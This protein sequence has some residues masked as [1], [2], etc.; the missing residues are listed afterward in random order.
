MIRGGQ[1]SVTPSGP[2]TLK[3]PKPFDFVFSNL[4]TNLGKTL[5]L[6]VKDDIE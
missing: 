4:S 3:E 2:P 1:T 5:K 6:E